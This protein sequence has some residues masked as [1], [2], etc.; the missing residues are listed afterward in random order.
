LQGVIEAHGGT[1]T[2]RGKPTGCIHHPTSN[3]LRQRP[4][5]LFCFSIKESDKP[6]SHCRSNQ[7]NQQ[8][9][10]KK[11]SHPKPTIEVKRQERTHYTVSRR[12]FCSNNCPQHQQQRNK[13]NDANKSKIKLA[14][15][16]VSI[17]S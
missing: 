16:R 12:T 1:I 4:W 9:F 10:P 3:Q 11:I 17:F 14:K 13:V 15:A 8:H 2:L 5:A 6:E 7:Q